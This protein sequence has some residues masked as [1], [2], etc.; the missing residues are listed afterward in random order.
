M[1]LDC[2]LSNRKMREGE[3]VTYNSHGWGDRELDRGCSDTKEVATEGHSLGF[4]T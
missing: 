2:A 4:G 3:E 1:I